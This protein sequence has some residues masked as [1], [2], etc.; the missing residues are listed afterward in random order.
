MNIFDIIIG[1]ILLWALYKGYRQGIAIQLAGLAGIVL[2]V[3]LAF[4]FSE[5]VSTWL[6]LDASY[7]RIVAFMCILVVTIILLALV[8]QLIKGLFNMVGLSIVDHLFGAILSV[9]KIALILGALLCALDTLNDNL[10]FINQSKIDSSVLYAPV[11]STAKFIFPYMDFL[12]DQLP[13][14]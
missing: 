2:G 3:Y 10:K 11:R 14:A 8:G 6:S 1:I 12:K 5:S 9:L 7:G 4:K 13:N